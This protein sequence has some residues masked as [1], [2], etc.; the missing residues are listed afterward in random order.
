[1]RD[2]HALVTQGDLSLP[3]CPH[4]WGYES[5]SGEAGVPGA[6]LTGAAE[7]G[8]GLMRRSGPSHPRQTGSK[9]K[10]YCWCPAGRSVAKVTG[11][12]LLMGTGVSALA[13][14]NALARATYRGGALRA[15]SLPTAEKMKVPSVHRAGIRLRLWEIYSYLFIFPDP[16]DWCA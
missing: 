3:F 9:D 13:P 2:S 6:P 14:R 16:W 5:F 7:A 10:P 8:A 12:F 15:L 1:M 11:N 4:R